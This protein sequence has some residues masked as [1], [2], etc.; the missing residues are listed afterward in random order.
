MPFAFKISVFMS[1]IFSEYYFFFE[2]AESS[3]R[4]GECA[5][6]S[7]CFRFNVWAFSRA[8]MVLTGCFPSKFANC[9]YLCCFLFMLF[10]VLFFVSCV[11]HRDG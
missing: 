6:I 1:D 7:P 2:C 3:R 5:E 11:A 10:V 8:V 4:D 9:K